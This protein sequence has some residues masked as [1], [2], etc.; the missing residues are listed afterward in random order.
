MAAEFSKEL[1]DHQKKT[2]KLAQK[3]IKLSEESETW[4]EES[5]ELA[6]TR[7]KLEECL[8]TVNNLELEMESMTMSQN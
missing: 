8:C 6:T 2:N 3:F 4:K 1:N 5:I 7:I